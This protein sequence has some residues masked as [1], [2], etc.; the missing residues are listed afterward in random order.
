MINLNE[1]FPGEIFLPVTD[2]AVPNIIQNTY[3]ISN[4]GRVYNIKLNLLRKQQIENS[5]YYTVTFALT[6]GSQKRVGVHRIELITFNPTENFQNLMVNHIDGNKLNNFIN[7]LEWV[8]ASGNIKHAYKIN[9]KGSGEDHCN[10]VYT[11][12]QIRK[13][14]ESLENELSYSE[15]ARSVGL[16]D[17]H[18]THCLISDIKNQISWTSISCEY[19]LTK[20]RSNRL[21]TDDEVVEVYKLIKKENKPYNEVIQI[22]N[23]DPN[24]NYTNVFN[25]IKWER[26]YTHLTKPGKEK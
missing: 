25:S 12:A 8:D 7:N 22:L 24:I 18:K 15:I 4:Y 9:L 13:I 1:V 10:A 16:P 23:L 5:G 6:D 20:K 19:D 2:L 26:R 17:T 11:S 21:L 14:C 3:F